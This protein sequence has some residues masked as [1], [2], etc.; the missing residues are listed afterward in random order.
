MKEMAELQSQKS[1]SPP[2]N[3]QQSPRRPDVPASVLQSVGPAQNSWLLRLFQSNHCDPAMTVEYLFKTSEPGVLQYLANKLFTFADSEVDKYLP[4][5]IHMYVH[6][7]EV[8]E[9]I[10]QYLSYRCCHGIVFSLRVSWLLSCTLNNGYL[11]Q[12]ARSRGR[13]LHFLITSED[14]RPGFS[15]RGYVTAPSSS[16]HQANGSAAK[17]IANGQVARTT[18][19]RASVPTMDMGERGNAAAAAASASTGTGKHSRVVTV[20]KDFGGGHRRSKSDLGVG[21]MH[22]DAAA[23]QHHHYRSNGGLPHVSSVVQG[24]GAMSC[25]LGTGI[26]FNNACGC[27]LDDGASMPSGPTR[28]IASGTVRPACHC[29]AARL[30][31]VQDFVSSLEE[32]G[33]KLPPLEQKDMQIAQL[34]AEISQINLNLPARIPLI[35]HRDGE[36]HQI[37]RIPYSEVILLNSRTKAPFFLH[38]EVLT[39]EDTFLSP[40]VPRLLD[41]SAVPKPVVSTVRSVGSS[42]HHAIPSAP[43]R[44]P[45]PTSTSGVV[46][47]VS[48]SPEASTKPRSN[49]LAA[50]ASADVNFSPKDVYERLKESHKNRRRQYTDASV[51]LLKEPW[52]EKVQRIRKS[53]PYGHYP[54]WQL[55]PVI[56]KVGDDLRQESL[57][58][59]LIA[60][61]DDVWKKENLNLWLRPYEVLPTSIDGG[62]IEPICN[63]VSLHQINQ[64]RKG[65]DTL[66]QYFYKEFGSERSESF[67]TARQNFVYSSAAYCLVCYLLQV[68]DRH[69]GNILLDDEGHIIHIDFGFI[70]NH[71]PGGNLG[72]ETSPFKMTSDFVEVMGG[73]TSDMYRYFRML[74]LKGLVASRKHIE[75]FITLVDIM[76]T[77]SHMPCFGRGGSGVRQMRERF[78]QGLTDEQLE[79]HVDALL[80]RSIY[81]MSTKLYDG[82]QYLTNG[83]M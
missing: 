46:F 57:A 63:A 59:Q 82:F 41:N 36:R 27:V 12:G 44:Q 67:L 24:T 51:A 60:E 81:S 80:S 74:L 72:F 28:G 6:Q 47:S 69:N 11:S 70:M 56:I 45:T 1:C 18:S 19:A 20:R 15:S 71:S 30:N 40:L 50:P 75:R 35:I 73:P 66:L 26:A 76:G 8:A 25:P 33:R 23:A 78:C 55:L 38:V 52:H 2:H 31:P 53:S 58:C 34:K 4:Q 14:L 61:F 32:I 62:M 22:V 13:R 77:G 49:D 37:A 21:H 83:I 10:N 7:E 42:S 48:D 29:G 17:A 68:K 43:S 16:S 9:A 39:C 64:Q 5:I 3:A 79:D 54:N 65:Q